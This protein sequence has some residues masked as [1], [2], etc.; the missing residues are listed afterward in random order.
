MA[1]DWRAVPVDQEQ[2]W[3]DAFAAYP[4]TAALPAPCPLCGA[5]KLRQYYGRPKDDPRVLLGVKYKGLGALWEW[6]LSCK[7]YEHYS[8]LVPEAWVRPPLTIPEYYLKACP[9]ELAYAL[10]P[11]ILSGWK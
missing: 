6:C 8:C 9:E 10:E 4:Y 7:T 1:G 2:A 11:V 3:R 5:H